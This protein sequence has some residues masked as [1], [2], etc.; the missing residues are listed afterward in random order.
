[1]LSFMHDLA[2][3]FR[4]TSIHDDPCS[5]HPL[6]QRSRPVC[7]SAHGNRF[8]GEFMSTTGSANGR[9]IVEGPRGG[10]KYLN[11]NGNWTYLKK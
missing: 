3:A 4:T 8:T 6:H 9:P 7:G 10:L 11:A 5:S 1:M 2:A